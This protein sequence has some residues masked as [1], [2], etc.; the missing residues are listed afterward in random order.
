[1]SLECKTCI[2][3]WQKV[4]TFPIIKCSRRIFFFLSRSS[5][6]TL[7][8]PGLAIWTPVEPCKGRLGICE[9]AKAAY[10]LLWISESRLKCSCA[11]TWISDQFLKVLLPLSS[12]F[13]YSNQLWGDLAQET[14]MGLLQRAQGSCGLPVTQAVDG[15]VQYFILYKTYGFLGS[16][17]SS[18]LP[19]IQKI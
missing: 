11:Y 8:T 12:K 19:Y 10:M 2:G 18:A 6:V 9:H 7:P 14:R 1:M 16:L 13:K 3:V 4:V 17:F 5:C 15:K